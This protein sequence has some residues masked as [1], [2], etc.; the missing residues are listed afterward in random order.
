MI[1]PQISAK[2]ADPIMKRAIFFWVN[3]C[4]EMMGQ[5]K[6]EKAIKLFLRKKLKSSQ[7]GINYIYALAEREFYKQKHGAYQQN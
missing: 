6:S 4:V 7:T 5:V 1:N 2:L 3:E